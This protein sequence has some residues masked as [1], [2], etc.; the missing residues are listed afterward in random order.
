MAPGVGETSHHG[1][2][3]FVARSM[4][5]PRGF[6][7]AHEVLDGREVAHRFP[8]FLNLAGQ[9]E[10]LLRARRRVRFSGALHQGAT[11][12]RASSSAQDP[13]GSRGSARSR[14]TAPAFAWNRPDGVSGPT[15]SWCAAGAWTAPPAR[16]ARSTACSRSSGRCCTGTPRRYRRVSRRR[17]GLHLDARSARKSITSTASRRCPAMRRIKVATEQYETTTRPMRSTAP[18]VLRNRPRCTGST[19]R[20]GSPARRR[21]SRRR[22]PASTR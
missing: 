2:P 9:R 8:Q 21:A 12:A 13:H 22:R 4:R 11:D 18:S 1:K 14:R 17:A 19:S 7:I 6:G 10:G 16:R 3:D 20:G 5:R 15:R